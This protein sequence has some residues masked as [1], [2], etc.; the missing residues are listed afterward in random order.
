MIDVKKR[1]LLVA[2]ASA[3][4]TRS[5]AE[6]A[7]YPNRPIEL[8][9]PYAAGGTGDV[10]ARALT[11]R[12]SR[13]LGQSIIVD[14]RS[15]ANG[16]IGAQVVVRSEADGYTLLLMATGHVI[17]PSL[18][19]VRYDWERQLTPVFGVTDTPLVFTVRSTSKIHSIA[20]LV[21]TA[22][23]TPL[24]INY[25][26]G[27]FGSI[28][29]LSA[30]LLLS[31]QKVAG[32]HIPYRGFS[33]AIQALMGEQVDFI[34]ATVADVLQLAKSGYLR[35][36]AVT[37]EQRQPLLPAVPTMAELGFSDFIASSWNTYMAPTGTP[38]DAID[39]LYDAFERAAGDITVRQGV[40]RLG[41]RVRSMSQAE[42]G[43]FLQSE[44]ARWH[45]VIEENGIKLQN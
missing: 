4:V 1:A 12:T 42:L 6:S 10:I 31:Q 26:S 3:L 23:T 7:R 39:I 24:G 25:A 28:S 2:T 43:K 34:C 8:I 41:A 21:A 14:N 5:F 22:K 27:G 20:E 15:G 45:R 38:H 37:A 17:L 44:A 11:E 16:I 32:T 18:Q 40:E 33:E 19:Q 9:V 29:H 30:A 13:S 36:L 35:V